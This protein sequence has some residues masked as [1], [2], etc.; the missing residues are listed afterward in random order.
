M[1]Q[2]LLLSILLL[3][4]TPTIA[5]TL[6]ERNYPPKNAQVTVESSNLPLVWITVSDTLSRYSRTLG[7]MKVI[8]N[9]NGVNYADTV[10][11]QNQ[12]VEFDGPI[13]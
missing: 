12:T 8:N 1:K 11:H 4:T 7:H 3:S 13:V 10:S 6:A 2:T 9:A 5:Q